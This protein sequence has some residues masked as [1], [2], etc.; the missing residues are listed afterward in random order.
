M[1]FDESEQNELKNK[2]SPKIFQP[3]YEDFL[4]KTD[5]QSLEL[6]LSYREKYFSTPEEKDKLLDMIKIQFSADGVFDTLEQEVFHFL[7]RLM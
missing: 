5:Y 2:F 7:N 1:D 3:V 6:I 4:N